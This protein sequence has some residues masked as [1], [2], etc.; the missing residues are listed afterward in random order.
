MSFHLY[1]KGRW[2]LSYW[3]QLQIYNS[4][5]AHWNQSK[6]AWNSELFSVLILFL[7]IF[8]AVHPFEAQADGE[9]NLSVDDYVVV[10]QVG[11]PPRIWFLLW[12]LHKCRLFIFSDN[13]SVHCCSLWVIIFSITVR[14]GRKFWITRRDHFPDVVWM[15]NRRNEWTILFSYSKALV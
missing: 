2:P 3:L 6:I 11:E 8:Q 10:R 5:I 9:L 13:Q 7:L 14:K 15:F 12:L 1:R 4:L